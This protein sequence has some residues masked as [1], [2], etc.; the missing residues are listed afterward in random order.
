VSKVGVC[1]G[2]Y[3]DSE[4]D[5]GGQGPDQHRDCQGRQQHGAG[6]G[7]RDCQGHQPRRRPRQ[8]EVC[9]GDLEPHVALARLRPRLRLRGLQAFG[10]DARLDCGAQGA[11]ARTPPHERGSPSV[12]GGDP[13]RHPQRNAAPQYV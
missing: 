7:G 13:L 12:P 10:E 9:Q 3:D 6:D 5:W 2:S 11:H 1:D 4:G 8:R